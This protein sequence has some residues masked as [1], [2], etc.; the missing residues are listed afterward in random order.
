[1]RT[2]LKGTAL[3]L[4]VAATA[5]TLVA[6]GSNAQGGGAP[7]SGSYVD[8]GTFT[9]AVT[10]DPGALDPQGSALAVVQQLGMFSY[11]NLVNIDIKNGSIHSALASS[12]KVAGK[13][14]TLTLKKGITCSDGTPFTA[15]DV[16]KNITY[17]ADPKNK[18][19]LL[20]VYLPAGA[21]AKATGDTVTITTPSAAPFILNGLASLPMV[22]GKGL[23]DRSYLKEH[24]SG[25]GLYDLTQVV[26]GDSYT[27]TLRKDYAWGPNG[28]TSKTKGLPA[29]VVVKV[30]N[31]ETTAANLLLSGGLNA[32]AIAGQDAKRLE[33][34]HLYAASTQVVLG[35]MWFNHTAPRPTS[36]PAVRMALTRAVDL[37]QLQKVLTAGA[38]GPATGL[39]VV[40]PAACPGDSV[41]GSV[42]SFDANAAAQALDAAGWKKGPDGIRSRDGK[43]LK[44][45][46]LIDS[47]IGAGATPT[48]ELATKEWGDLGV[49]VVTKP[50]SGSALQS[51]L[52]GTGDW[53]I[54]LITLNVSS[55]DQLV[56]FLSGAGPAKGGTN[57][58]SIDNKAYDQG[59]AAAMKMPGTQGCKTWLNAESQLFKAADVVP[60]A[61][62]RVS[63]FGKG[64][65]F[66]MA[67][68]VLPW[69]IRMTSR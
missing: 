38:G 25:T 56:P 49:K 45:T 26:P 60:F 33:A 11:D 42:P 52:F 48:A 62:Q 67:G 14:T 12:W 46:L 8:G 40:D 24:A 5:A 68:Q 18:S 23:T 35:E 21:T 4:A 65:V 1:M 9:L 30:V 53:D 43:E 31:N 55:P 37:G 69:T 36:E 34:A 6:C 50:S 64:A 58:S 29:T 66:Q 10:E 22:C 3:G 51:S 7:G 57:F 17:L 41:S 47:S 19:P 59:V 61:N 28:L 16:V 32:A 15:A 54:A 13:T 39:A 44:L 27:F 2:I 20:G 63:V